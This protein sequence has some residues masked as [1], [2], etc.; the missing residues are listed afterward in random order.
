MNMSQLHPQYINEPYIINIHFNTTLPFLS[1]SFQ[2][3]LPPKFLVNF[4]FLQ[5]KKYVQ[6]VVTFKQ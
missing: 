5:F 3:V 1:Q 4:L 2:E 6:S